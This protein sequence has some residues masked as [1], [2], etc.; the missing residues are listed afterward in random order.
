MSAL[1]RNVDMRD[2]TRC[3][4]FVPIGDIFALMLLTNGGIIYRYQHRGQA[5][6]ERAGTSQ[7]Y[8]KEVLGTAGDGSLRMDL[9]SPDPSY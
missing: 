9:G 1:R 3:V 4:C 2:A 6:A 7:K 8:Q 5:A